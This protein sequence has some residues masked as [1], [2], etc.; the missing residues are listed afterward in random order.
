[1]VTAE[2]PPIP[3]LPN[4]SACPNC[5]GGQLQL[6]RRVSVS[7]LGVPAEL[8]HCPACDFLFLGDPTWLAAAYEDSFYGDTGY[9]D[10]NLQASRLL[11]LLLVIG[12]LGRFEGG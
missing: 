7:K 2:A 9:V 11:R 4:T 10:R 1:M 12:R 3:S 8:V 5:G 6:V